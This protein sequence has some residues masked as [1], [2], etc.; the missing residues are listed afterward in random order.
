MVKKGTP[1]KKPGGP[2]SI[3]RFAYL[4]LFA[5]RKQADPS[6]TLVQ[7]KLDLLRGLAAVDEEARKQGHKVKVFDKHTSGGR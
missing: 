6:L 4:Q 7:F 5:V 1:C 3:E 2:I